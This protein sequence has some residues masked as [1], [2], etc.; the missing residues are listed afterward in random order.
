[1]LERILIPLDGSELADRIL[2]QMR[3]ILSKGAEVTLLGVVP[4]HVLP[5]D[6]PP[7]KNPLTLA[8]AHLAARRDELVA[9]GVVAKTALSVGDAAS[10]ILDHARENG[11]TLIA[12]STHGRT[13]AQRMIRGSIAERVLR[14]SPVPVLLANPL[15]LAKETELRFERILV[16]LD[17]SERAAEIIPR[18]VELA[19]VH[20]SEV[21]LTYSVPVDVA[22]EPFVAVGPVMTTQD[23]DKI[24]QGYHAR[25]YDVPVRRIV[26]LG[27]P[28]TNILDIVE[29]E[30]VGLVA[31]TTHGR[32]GLARWFFGSVAE[33]VTRHAKC[34]LL[35]VRNAG[36]GATPSQKLEAAKPEPASATR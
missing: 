24:L 16:P 19:R 32:T 34:P 35:V 15:A 33:Q 20:G 28:A 14:H 31:M 27:D 10:K 18:V 23:G 2:P 29:R 12:M 9:L 11:T 1:M 21:L 25:F 8:R 3:G 30:K 7:G 22:V 36:P 5:Q 4:S 17:G 6:H 13:G 26:A